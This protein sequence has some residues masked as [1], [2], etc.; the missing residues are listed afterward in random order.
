MLGSCGYL[1]RCSAKE[2][3]S[4]Q[5]AERAAPFSC[6]KP[7]CRN[8]FVRAC[9]KYEKATEQPIFKRGEV[10]QVHEKVVSS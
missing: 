1:E 6:P 4:A 2:D 7:M 3:D 8:Y 5:Q 10:A 9:A